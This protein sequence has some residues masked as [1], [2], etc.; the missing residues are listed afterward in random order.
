MYSVKVSI[1]VP[2]IGDPNIFENQPF[3]VVATRPMEIKYNGASTR[4]STKEIYD[5][6]I[7]MNQTNQLLLRVSPQQRRAIFLAAALR[8]KHGETSSA[9]YLFN[10]VK[11]LLGQ[12][13]K[14]LLP[15][16]YSSYSNFCVAAKKAEDPVVVFKRRVHY[17]KT[18]Y[19][20]ININGNS[21][22][23]RVIDVISHGVG[24]LTVEAAASL[25][26]HDI[27]RLADILNSFS[28]LIMALSKFDSAL[29][30]LNNHLCKNIEADCKGC[31]Y[32][33]TWKLFVKV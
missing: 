1:P 30:Q 2:L 22:S 20:P 18:E 17:V 25:R 10:K 33:P 32:I 9:G 6:V 5:E 16:V 26:R 19:V 15:L 23:P 4:M 27:D 12:E 11:T 13:W 3:I 8:L 24:L 21:L 29:L 31:A 7:K 14:E 28:S